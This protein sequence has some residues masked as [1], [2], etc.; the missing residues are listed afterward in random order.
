MLNER[1]IKVTLE[2][3][4]TEIK[5]FVIE[6]IGKMNVTGG[7]ALV[8]GTI[9]TIKDSYS[10]FEIIPGMLNKLHYGQ[11]RRIETLNC[12]FV[13]EGGEVYSDLIMDKI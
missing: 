1:F 8:N 2:I 6:I 3:L 10:S 9:G 7:S 13:E 4:K 12:D 5:L 11:P